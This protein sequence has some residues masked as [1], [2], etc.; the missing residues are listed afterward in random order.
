VARFVAIGWNTNAL[1]VGARYYE[2]ES[3]NLQ[4]RSTVGLG[5]EL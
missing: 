2:L 3:I 4:L 5:Q 1:M